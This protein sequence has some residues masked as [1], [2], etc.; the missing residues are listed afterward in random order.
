MN[1]RLGGA[2]A[3]VLAL[4]VGVAGYA[5]GTRNSAAPGLDRAAIEEMIAAATAVTPAPPAASMMP[6]GGMA[7][8]PNAALSDDARAEVEG[9]IRNYLIANPEIVRDAIY[10]LQRKEDAAA[11]EEQI[12]AITANKDKIFSS[13]HQVVLGNPKGDV[14][15]VEFFDYNCSYCR[16]AHADMK[17]LIADDPNLRVV[18]KEFPILSEE[19][20]QAAQ[21]AVAVLLT[22]PEKYGAFHD[23]LI[24]EKG[25]VD[26][27]KALA[28]A[29]DIG[30]DTA[31]IR[32]KADSDDVKANIGEARE[33]AETLQLT[34]TP[35]YVTASAVVI[36]AA[37]Y[38]ALKSEIA[39]AREACK[40]ETTC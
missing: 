19:S 25:L 27:A 2:I 20:M 13:A 37:G 17:Q 31:A 6:A 11:Q 4:A 35:S 33:L 8:A 15:L 16:R 29:A 18:L 38:D 21:V 14:T 30:L 22:A 23:E 1:A 5:I 7:S 39:K 36:G 24:S 10:E 28:V 3:A 40:Q 26:G 34:G 12:A 9:M 32:A